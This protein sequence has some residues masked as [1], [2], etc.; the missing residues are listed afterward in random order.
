MVTYLPLVMNDQLNSVLAILGKTYTLP[1]ELRI[2]IS[3]G[4]ETIPPPPYVS[5]QYTSLENVQ[6]DAQLQDVKPARVAALEEAIR[7]AHLAKV[8]GEISLRI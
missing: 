8:G 6:D 5:E 4:S 3:G 2:K 1:P 7:L